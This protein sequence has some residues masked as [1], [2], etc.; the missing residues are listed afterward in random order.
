M[1]HVRPAKD[2]MSKA[3]FCAEAMFRSY[4]HCVQ[5]RIAVVGQGT[6]QILTAKPEP[7]LSISFTPPTVSHTNTCLYVATIANLLSVK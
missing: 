4:G 6:G 7:L 5:V 1:L 2:V 3:M